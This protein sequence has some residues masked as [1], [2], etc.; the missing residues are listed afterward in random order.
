MSLPATVGWAPSPFPSPGSASLTWTAKILFLLPS[1][2]PPWTDLMKTGPT[3][4]SSL[5]GT[6]GALC[7]AGSSPW[8]QGPPVPASF[9]ALPSADSLHALYTS[10]KLCHKTFFERSWFC[11]FIYIVFEPRRPLFACLPVKILSFNNLRKMSQ[12]LWDFCRILGLA[13]KN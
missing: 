3:L 7:L 12:P 8:S 9:P 2:S 10:G 6:T 5:H 1:R 4:R 11:T 13:I